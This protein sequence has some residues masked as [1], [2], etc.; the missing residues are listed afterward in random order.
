MFSHRQQTQQRKNPC[1]GFLKPKTHAY[2]L[3][4]VSCTGC[5]DR[6]N[7]YIAPFLSVSLSRGLRMRIRQMHVVA[8]VSLAD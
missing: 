3:R 8:K 2:T 6:L 7:V 4:A 1:T 5:M